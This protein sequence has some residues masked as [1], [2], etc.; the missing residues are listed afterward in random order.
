MPYGFLRN[1]IKRLQNQL[2]KIL[3]EDAVIFSKNPAFN[4]SFFP[5]YKIIKDLDFKSD[6]GIKAIMLTTKLRDTFNLLNIR[7]KHQQAFTT[8]LENLIII[9]QKQK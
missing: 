2:I 4:H 8:I 9:V 5:L 6:F 7:W 3:D 1:Q